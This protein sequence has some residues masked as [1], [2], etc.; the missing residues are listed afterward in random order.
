M[1]NILIVEDDANISNLVKYNLSKANFKCFAERSGENVIHIL[2]KTRFDLIILDIM[3]TGMDGFEVCK[4][5]RLHPDFKSIPII[6]LTARGEEIDRILGLELGADDYVVKPFS[7]RELVLRV[8]SILKRHDPD[9]SADTVIELAGIKIDTEAHKI[10]INGHEVPFTSKEFALLYLLVKRK[11]K[12]QTR[13]SLLNEIWDVSSDVTTRTVDTH[14][15]KLRKKLENY[16]QYIET[17]HG[18]GYKF[19]EDIN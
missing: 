17:V 18:I 6:M 15:K 9:E 12:V 7:P 3:L 2:Q 11:G 4:R 19:R 14:I 1:N 5:I 13:E 8:K 16:G 10:T